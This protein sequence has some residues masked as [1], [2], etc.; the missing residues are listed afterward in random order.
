MQICRGG[1]ELEPSI[2][3]DWSWL[4]KATPGLILVQPPITAGTVS[5][6]LG[7]TSVTL[8]TTPQNYLASNISV[9]NWFFKV[10]GHPDVFKVSAHTSGATSVTL[11]GVYTGATAATAGYTLFLTDYN[12]ATDCLRLVAPMRVYRNSGWGSRDDYKI[13]AADL[14]A[15]EEAYPLSLIEQGVPDLYAHIGET[16]QATKRIRFNRCGGGQGST[17]TVYRIEYEY[18]IIPTALTNPGTAE[19]PLL[20][21]EY[22]H[23]LADF[24]L[25]YLFGVKNDDRAGAA[26]QIAQRGLQ[27]MARENRYK[28]T[29]ATRNSFRVQPRRQSQRIR[30]PKRTESGHIIG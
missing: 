19:L 24:L 25:A 26:A 29:T 18:L 20:P 9:A 6:T 2:Y 22:R 27:G 16:T 3:E 15:I 4:R 1:S 10:E 23:I 13:Y 21:Y 17:T 8:S 14:D 5:V 30:G 28:T 11:D 7:N 12:L